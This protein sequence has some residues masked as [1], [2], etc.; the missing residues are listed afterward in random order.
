[1]LAATVSFLLIASSA[2]R[3]YI[4]QP[5]MAA[6]AEKCEKSAGRKIK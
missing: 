6:F 5:L 2:D 4:L 3:C 1:M